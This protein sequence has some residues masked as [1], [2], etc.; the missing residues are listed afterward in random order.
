MCDGKGG[1]PC[2]I[3][4]YECWLVQGGLLPKIRT[5]NVVTSSNVVSPSTIYMAAV[6][7]FLRFIHSYNHQIR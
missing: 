1:G 5:Y 2:A 7:N 4:H 3:P 6:V